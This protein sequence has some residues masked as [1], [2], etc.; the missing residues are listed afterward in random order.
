M[1]TTGTA[2]LLQGPNRER[3]TRIYIRLLGSFVVLGA[4][5]CG[6]TSQ[7]TPVVAEPPV[8]GTSNYVLAYEDVAEPK[9]TQLRKQEGLDEVTSGARTDLEVFEALTLWA[10][11]QFEPGFPDP[12]PLSNGVDILTDIRSGRTGGFCG[13]YAYLLADALKSYGHFSVR[14]VETFARDDNSHFLVEVWSN[15]LARWVLLDPLYAAL[16]VD[17]NGEPLSMWDAHAVAAGKGPSG[18]HRKWLA[19]ETEVSREPD[20]GYF[21]LFRL[22][23]IS[24]RNNLAGEMKPW[25]IPERRQQF[26]ALRDD[27]NKD[28][29]PGYYLHES[30]RKEDFTAAR[31][32]CRMTVLRAVDGD[33]LRLDNLGSCPHFWKFQIR[34]NGGEWRDAAW[35][36]LHPGGLESVDC[37]PVNQTGLRG[38]VTSLS[39]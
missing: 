29:L 16:V 4:L 32:V 1:T 6:P 15:R 26:L 9:V 25:S 11:R 10:R 24:L 3:A 31:N 27:T 38:V 22:P 18:V 14:Y 20:E 34:L 35:E 8:G 5:S 33:V 23:A 30:N 39:M 28:L 36:T 17:E 7:D 21:E 19:S 12:Y 2:P 37:V 13:Q